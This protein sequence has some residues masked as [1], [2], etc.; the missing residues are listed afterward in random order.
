[1]KL[2]P[3]DPNVLDAAGHSFVQFDDKPKA[4]EA[5]RRAIEIAPTFSG[6]RC[7]LFDLLV[8]QDQWEEAARIIRELPRLDQ[9]PSVLAR[10]MRM[11][12]HQQAFDQVEADLD[13]I[14]HSEDWSHWAI[15]QAVEIMCD[16]G[17]EDV[18]LQRVEQ[19]LADP[20]SNEDLG[21]VWV[22]LKLRKPVHTRDSRF[23][24]I[25]QK[26]KSWFDGDHTDAGLAGIATFVRI[27]SGQ[28]Q[29]ATLNRYIK[30]NGDWLARDT[31]SWSLVAFAFADNP[32][33]YKKSQMRQWL[34]GWEMRQDFKPWMFTNV[35]EL[36]RLVGD[37]E[38][39]RRAVRKALELPA[40]HMQSQLRLWAA[41]DALVQ[42]DSQLALRHYMGAARLEHLDGFDR[43]LHHWVE[44]V[45]YILQAPDKKAAFNQIREQLDALGVTASFFA[46]QPVFA[47]VYS[48]TVKTLAAQTG[49]IGAKLWAARKLIPLMYYRR[50]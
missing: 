48:H 15:D 33:R 35:H 24:A 36:C 7:A 6:S 2:Q 41:H 14:L 4:I 16:A 9:H 39:G 38:G 23:E 11:S 50:W 40:D 21:R 27:L 31:K 30:K 13:A 5:F 46:E 47:E 28:G 20:S 1:M 34:K 3:H 17:K 29:F 25:F 18:I 37:L 19:R 12:V 32:S 26:L 8:E 44:S 49:T 43:L 22:E 45:I 42:G 10:R